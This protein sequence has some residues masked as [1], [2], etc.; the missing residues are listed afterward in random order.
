MWK[1]QNRIVLVDFDG[2]EL[3]SGSSVFAPRNTAPASAPAPRT[4]PPVPTQSG[5][6]RRVRPQT[7]ELGDEDIIIEEA[8]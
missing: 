6:F 5:V 8:A 7:E 1:T 2:E 3:L 4:A